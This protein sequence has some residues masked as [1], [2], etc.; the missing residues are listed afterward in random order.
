MEGQALTIAGLVTLGSMT[1]LTGAM[2]YWG[3]KLQT[4]VSRLDDGHKDHEKRLR[5]IESLNIRALEKLDTRLI[6]R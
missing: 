3:G 2:F 1:T 5:S 4:I 6:L